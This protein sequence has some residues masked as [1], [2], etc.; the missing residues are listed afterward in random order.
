M[1]GRAI[2]PKVI[3]ST[4][5]VRRAGA[6]IHALFGRPS[7][8]LFPPPGVDAFETFFAK[9]DR[10]PAHAGRLYVGV[11]AP[12]R[13]Q[14]AILLRTYVALLAAAGQQHA[15]AGADAAD[16]YM[17]L[18]GYFNSLR[19]L[20]GM[21]R[22]VEDDVRTRCSSIEARVPEN[23][24]GPHAWGRNRD[25][26]MPVELTSRAKAGA[27]KDAKER[28]EQRYGAKGHVDALLASNMI[29]VGVDIDRLGLM[30]VAG[31]PKSTSEYIQA[32][33]RVGRQH[34]GLV[35]TC[36]NVRRPRDRSHYERFV[37][38]HESF[39]RYVEAT[40][41]TPFSGP[42][43]DRGLAGTLIA[44]ARL[45]HS[46]LTPPAA[47][48]EIGKQR[49]LAEGSVEAIAAR[50]AAQARETDDGAR[51]TK[52][53]RDRGHKLVEAWE[54][55]TRIA[56]D[57]GGTKRSYSRF[58][59]DRTAGKPL[60]FQIV[61]DDPPPPLSDEARF[62]APTSMRDVEPSVHLW[63]ERRPLGGRR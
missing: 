32:S 5:T 15:G 13:P 41:L 30:V 59:R 33:S 8:S 24:G 7:M 47:A 25:V 3:A 43:L 16:P 27:I 10:D 29:S 26:K 36:F 60:L 48:M 35:V 57:E 38:Y 17:T 28:L 44:M 6:Q 11:A 45:G 52:S 18:A 50:G 63:L 49:K 22:L 37:A 1:G 31:Q 21:R 56:R 2:R 51:L 61:D 42:A 23:H 14:K 34:P 9:L 39:Y 58:D 53:L 40:S 20:G 54:K 62:A 55:L 4:A 46:T 12:G 19:E